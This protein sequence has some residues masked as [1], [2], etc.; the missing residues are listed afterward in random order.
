MLH[1]YEDLKS[2]ILE[3]VIGH[4]YWAVSF[5]SHPQ[6]LFPINSYSY[7]PPYLL[8]NVHRL[9]FTRYF[10]SENISA[11]ALFAFLV[12]LFNYDKIIGHTLEVAGLKKKMKETPYGYVNCTPLCITT[13]SYSIKI[14]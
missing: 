5:N 1:A 10:V 12:Q 6:K 2:L 11:Y 13:D 4:E 7:Y 8:L 3:S 14:N 9:R